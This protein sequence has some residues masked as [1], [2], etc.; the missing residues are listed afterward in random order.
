MQ[1]PAWRSHTLIPPSKSPASMGWG[2][3]FISYVHTTNVV[4]K[5][6]KGAQCGDHTTRR[7]TCSAW[8]LPHW[9]ASASPDPNPAPSGSPAHLPPNPPVATTRSPRQAM[10]STSASCCRSRRRTDTWW[11]S[12]SS[13]MHTL[14]LQPVASTCAQGTWG[15]QWEGLKQHGVAWGAGRLASRMPD[16]HSPSCVHLMSCSSLRWHFAG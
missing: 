12:P 3:G 5:F 7:A 1:Q 4:G 11:P 14:R 15:A 9:V 8:V 6:A 16:M 10:Q 2:G 13:Q